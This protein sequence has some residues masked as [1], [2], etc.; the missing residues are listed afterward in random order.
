MSHARLSFVGYPQYALCL[1]G[2]NTVILGKVYTNIFLPSEYL[3]SAELNITL[4][5]HGLMD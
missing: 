1:F 2:M 5:T 4:D 3:I